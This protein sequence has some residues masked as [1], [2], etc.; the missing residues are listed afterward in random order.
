MKKSEVGEV[1]PSQTLTT[2]GIGSLVDLPNM[3]VIV[4]GLDDWPNGRQREA[5]HSARQV[6]GCGRTV[7]IL[8]FGES[9][10]VCLYDQHGTWHV[11]DEWAVAG[12]GAEAFRPTYRVGRVVLSLTLLLR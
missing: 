6:R 5:R 2:Y 10:R 9:D 12:P 4:M 1:R 7:A 8:I 3:S 11:G